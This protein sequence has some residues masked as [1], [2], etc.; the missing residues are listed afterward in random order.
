MHLI[1]RFGGRLAR[2]HVRKLERTCGGF[3]GRMFSTNM[4]EEDEPNE[5]LDHPG[6]K[7]LNDSPFYRVIN[8]GS[9]E[10]VIAEVIENNITDPTELKFSLF[11]LTTFDLSADK[12]SR[13]DLKKCLDVFQS[14]VADMAGETEDFL[15]F[16]HCFSKALRG[17]GEPTDV[18]R[19]SEFLQNGEFNVVFELFDE[20]QMITLLN[21]IASIFM[22]EIGT[23][24][25]FF[26]TK[27]KP[28]VLKE[29]PGYS[30]DGQLN[31]LLL[32]RSTEYRDL[33]LMRVYESL[34]QGEEG[35]R[36]H[37]IKFLSIMNEMAKLKPEV[38]QKMVQKLSTQAILS[39]NPQ[40]EQE[41]RLSEEDVQRKRGPRPDINVSVDYR[42]AFDEI[43]SD[44]LVELG[45]L[46][47]D[48][49]PENLD[50]MKQLFFSVLSR[51][52][53]LTTSEFIDLW[54]ITSKLS[55]SN[56]DFV[57]DPIV[58]ELRRL[59]IQKPHISFR[60]LTSEQL[61]QLLVALSSMK[62]ND[63]HLVALVTEMLVPHLD[64]LPIEDLVTLF[65]SYFVYSRLFEKYFVRIHDEI[66]A[67]IAQLTPEL[68]RQIRDPIEL[69]GELFRGSPI[70]NF[71]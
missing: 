38:V 44:V 18:S 40:E 67:K 28:V 4:D 10:E 32:M 57:K 68:V 65:R 36:N 60:T 24:L 52:A 9:V 58:A 3:A 25:W 37:K 5:F 41:E 2:G 66:V 33:D 15:S 6:L 53:S 16:F 29:L 21:S 61:V 54:L 51:H 13:K 59:G 64:S 26:E 71:F 49:V 48:Y 42:N 20:A 69:K 7:A 46:V 12:V 8:A 62:V 45:Y 19:I 1:R 23:F 14:R 34:S 17:L 70:R 11:N 27:L 31:I 43:N 22:F 63:T 47:L 55:K 30:E 39:T 56:K 50:F 35:N